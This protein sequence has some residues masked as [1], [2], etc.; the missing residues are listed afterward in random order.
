MPIPQVVPKV[1]DVALTVAENGVASIRVPAWSSP[2]SSGLASNNFDWL[3]HGFS[4]HRGGVSCAY[5]PEGSSAGSDHGQL[6]LG[7]TPADVAENVHENRLRWVE[8]VTGSRATPLVV[9][10]QIHSNRSL[11]APRD[12]AGIEQGSAPEADGILTN[13]R[14]VLIGIQTADCI[15]VLVADTKRRAVAAFHAGWRGTVA[16]I[17]ESGVARMREEFD[18]EPADLVAAIGPGIG[19]CCYTVGAQVLAK[20]SESFSYADELFSSGEDGVH[21]DLT[22]ANRRQLMTAG[23]PESSIAVVGGCTACQPE[24]FYSHRASGGHAGRMMAVIGIR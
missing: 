4:T 10:R 11:I 17:V 2:V 18:S 6:N 24:L 14:G 1:K 7:F 23:I 16:R 13:Q 20:F 15:P 12:W 5:M 9:V 21:L 22:E 19:A 3:W 8:A